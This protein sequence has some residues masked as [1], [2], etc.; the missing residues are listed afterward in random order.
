MKKKD[1]Y[2]I[3]TTYPVF[4]YKEMQPLWLNTVIHFLGFE[5]PELN[6]R[7][8]YLELA[9]ASGINLLVCA[10]NNPHASF[11]GV[12]FNLKHIEKAKQLAAQLE[13][14]NI[15]FIHAD[16][17]EFLNSNNKKFDFIVN[18]GTFSWISPTHQ[19]SILEIV[20]L[21]LKERGIFYVHYMC[22]PGSASLSP[23]QK[24]LNLVDQQSS[25]AS[26]ENIKVAKKLCNE[27]HQAGAFLNS[28]EI[29]EALKSFHQQDS[30]LAHEFLTD[31]WQPLY[32][33][34]VHKQ[35][36]ECA[37]LSYLGSANPCENLDSISIPENMQ[38]IIR[39]A[40]SPIIKE[41]LKDLARNAKQRVDIFQKKPEVLDSS[42]HM[43]KMSQIRFKLLPQAPLNGISIFN[44]PIGAIQAPQNLIAT[45][46]KN[47]AKQ[48]LTFS[49]FMA[50]PVFQ[51]NPVFLIETLFLLM[52]EGYIHPVT[53]LDKKIDQNMIEKFNQLMVNERINLKMLENCGVAI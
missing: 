53:T 41:Y 43:A 51:S 19:H 26:I 24:L 37:A 38:A 30:Y 32:S 36:H 16:F 33:V 10:I 50:D 46:F 45:M 22:Y 29:N 44:T 13:L 23:I 18:H 6:Q 15:E 39:D 31:H 8:S 42:V 14:K 47:L 21:F 35:V 11:V 7:F 49:A 5:T 40:S 4:F 9:C 28:P 27:L 34:D 20:N 17:A 12:D 25:E 48:D 3:D 1:G 2:V 52:N